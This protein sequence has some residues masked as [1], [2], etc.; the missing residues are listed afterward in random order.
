M[1][2]SISSPDEDDQAT[3]ADEWERLLAR[4]EQTASAGRK[5]LS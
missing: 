3:P 4:E 5:S 2:R 1:A